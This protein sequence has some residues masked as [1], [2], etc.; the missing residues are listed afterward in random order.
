MEL[1]HGTQDFV[2][3]AKRNRYIASA[4]LMPALGNLIDKSAA[5]AARAR[6]VRLALAAE[7]YRLKHSGSAPERMDEFAA[8]LPASEILDPFDGQ[9]LRYQ[10]NTRG[11]RIYSV[12]RDGAGGMTLPAKAGA[13]SPGGQKPA[14]PKPGDLVFVVVK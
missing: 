13:D 8:T 9:P 6:I 1:G 14:A 3:T 11:Y 5:H 7:G 4:L 10:K 2:E 12:G